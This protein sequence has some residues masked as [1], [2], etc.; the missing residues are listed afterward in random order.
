MTAITIFLTPKINIKEEQEKE[1]A[2]QKYLLERYIKRNQDKKLYL[3]GHFDPI[4]RDDFVVIPE[5]YNISGYKMY[6]RR[7]A[8]S[9]FID[10]AEDAKKS[11]INLK[12]ASATR[13]FNYQKSLWDKKWTGYTLVEGADLSK[14]I[15]NG[16]DRFQKILEYSAAPTTSRHHWGTDIDINNA[17]VE[18]FSTKEGVQVY[19]WLTANAS[20]Y[21][22]CQPYNTKDDNRPTGYNEERWHWSYTPLAKDFTKEYLKLVKDEDING[23]QGEE[24]VKDQNLIDEYVLGINPECL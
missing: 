3:T 7:E 15:P 11:G 1:E 5:K 6:L 22:F 10:M 23:F 2:L 16:L 18:Y 21:G 24:Y 4:L 20:S 12:I 14:T 8:L 9:A 17:N 13:N 19:D